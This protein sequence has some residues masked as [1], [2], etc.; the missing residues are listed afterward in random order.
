VGLLFTAPIT[1]I[2]ASDALAEGDA[3][4]ILPCSLLGLAAGVCIGAL[5]AANF[6]MLEIEEQQHA[7]AHHSVHAHG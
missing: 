4:T 7:P 5:I 2:A 1:W 6:A 3:L